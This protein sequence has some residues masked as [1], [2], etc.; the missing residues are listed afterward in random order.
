MKLKAV[1]AAAVFAVVGAQ[2]E[3][4]TIAGDTFT[5]EV[6]AAPTSTV[7]VNGGFSESLG[8]VTGA[9]DL[10]VRT[11]AINLSQNS[12][13][14]FG[15]DSLISNGA[16]ADLFFVDGRFDSGAFDFSIDGSTFFSVASSD[17]VNTGITE[18]LT[19]SIFRFTVF[20]LEIDLSDFGVAS[21][22]T[23]D[24]LTLRTTN[25]ALDLMAV[26]ALGSETASPVPLPA[27]LPLLGTALIGL[28]IVSRHRKRK[29]TLKQVAERSPSS[30][31]RS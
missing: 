14:E 21:G 2:A 30:A 18:T 28:G 13:I 23:F 1:F 7:L 6:L 8:P 3:A 29:S 19:G 15:F 12:T 16:G 27:A 11:G 20:T 24:T 26:A 5:K 10:D 4:A 31:M 17:F 25:A 22:A 9:G